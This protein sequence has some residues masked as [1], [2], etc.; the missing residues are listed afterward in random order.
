MPQVLSKSH[1][2]VLYVSVG[3]RFKPMFRVSLVD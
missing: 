2:V 1:W 3:P